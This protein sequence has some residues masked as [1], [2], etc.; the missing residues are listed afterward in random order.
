MRQTTTFGAMRRTYRMARC[1]PVT[2]EGMAGDLISPDGKSIVVADRQGKNLIVAIDSGQ[3]RPIA[4]LNDD[5]KLAR[6]SADGR[7]LYLF[8]GKMPMKLYRLDLATGRR[9]LLKEIVPSDPS[10][11][12]VI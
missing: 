3:T 9:G 6:W 5:D 7:S 10:G 1:T 4:G 2:P 8:Q 12:V 11:A